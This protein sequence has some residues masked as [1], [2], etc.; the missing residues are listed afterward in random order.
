M[1]KN[2]MIALAL[3]ASLALTACS[4]GTGADQNSVEEEPSGTEVK[5]NESEGN[6]REITI[7]VGHSEAA[8]SIREDAVQYMNQILQETTGGKMKIESYPASQLGGL[9][10]MVE[11]VETDSLDAVILGPSILASYDPNNDCGA[12]QLPYLVDTYEQAWELVDSDVIAE[13]VSDLPENNLHFVC[14]W[15]AGFRNLTNSKNPVMSADDVKGLKIR[16]VESPLTIAIWNAFGASPTPMAFSEVYTALQSQVLDGQENPTSVNFASN[17]QEVQKYMTITKHQYE[18]VY[19][20]VSEN[21]WN[22]MSGDEKEAF[23]GACEKARDYARQEIVSSEEDWLVQM[24]EAGM[25][26]T[27]E[28]DV[29]SFRSHAAE[30]YEAMKDVYGAET[31]DNI[32]KK[33]EKIRSR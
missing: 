19:F 18:P 16:V 13:T 20:I 5:E 1:K 30:V 9:T 6:Y 12:I 23:L 11:Q 27:R 15:E 3:A 17:F 14:A 10:Q 31:V 22:D 2:I 7:K 32:V 21:K 28:F 26:I 24:E 4:A 33:A 25:E 8:T 29:D